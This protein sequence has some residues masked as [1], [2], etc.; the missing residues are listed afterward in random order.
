MNKR[1]DPGVYQTKRPDFNK[2]VKCPQP[3]IEFDF[4][5]SAAAKSSWGNVINKNGANKTESDSYNTPLAYA[6]REDCL[7]LN[8]Y[9]PKVTNLYSK[10]S[11]TTQLYPLLISTGSKRCN[12][13]RVSCNSICSRWR[14]SL[15]LVRLRLPCTQYLKAAVF[16]L[17]IQ[18]LSKAS[19]KSGALI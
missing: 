3:G 19:F 8:V 1:L 10:P 16:V 2:E 5:A 9:T 14:I 4:I 18:V 12:I 17:Q 11:I 7:V 15:R 6:G 13:G